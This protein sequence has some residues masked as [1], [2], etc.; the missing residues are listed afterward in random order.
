M[1]SR[2]DSSHSPTY[3]GGVGVT[4][5]VPFKP[6]IP[7]VST[8]RGR[9]AKSLSSAN[10]AVSIPSWQRDQNTTARDFISLLSIVLAPWNTISTA[11]YYMFAK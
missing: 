2:V 6:P 4:P 7:D 5:S 3:D 8:S 10:K 9:S 1:I 11:D